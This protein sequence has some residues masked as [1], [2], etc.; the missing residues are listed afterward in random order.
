MVQNLNRFFLQG[1]TSSEQPICGWGQPLRHRR[2]HQGSVT[3]GSTC[4]V[5]SMPDF[6]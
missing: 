4:Q 5:A 2:V 1:Y 3:C 6:L